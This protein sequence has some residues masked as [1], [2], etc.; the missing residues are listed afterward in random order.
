MWIILKKKTSCFMEETSHQPNREENF[1]LYR[2]KQMEKS[3][4]LRKLKCIKENYEKHESG[5]ERSQ[6]FERD[7]EIEKKLH[8][9]VNVNIKHILSKEGK[10]SETLQKVR[11]V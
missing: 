9:L 5:S 4:S 8:I 7:W 10:K 11:V 6:N 1:K 3:S 2:L